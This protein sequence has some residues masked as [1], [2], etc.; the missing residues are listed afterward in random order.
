MVRLPG[1][2]DHE[3]G[4]HGI[5]DAPATAAGAELDVEHS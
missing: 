2:W 4:A 1:V 5:V 3:I